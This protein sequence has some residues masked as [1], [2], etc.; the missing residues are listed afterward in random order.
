VEHAE[1]DL[2]QLGDDGRLSALWA[3]LPLESDEDGRLRPAAD[4][5]LEGLAANAFLS[6]IMLICAVRVDGDDEQ[7]RALLSDA[8]YFQYDSGLSSVAEE[9]AQ[10]D[11]AYVSVSTE[12]DPWLDVPLQGGRFLDNRAVASVNRTR[13]ER[14][15]RSWEAA[16]GRPIT[17]VDSNG[18]PSFVDRYGFRPGGQPDPE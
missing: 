14:A 6:R 3:E 8:I 5:V 12:V 17:E 11:S 7:Q 4:T 18:Y 16:M 10:F 9:P 1:G 15:L 2:A 13:L